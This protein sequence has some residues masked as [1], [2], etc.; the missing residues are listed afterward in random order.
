MG[1]GSFPGAVEF[2]F[3]GFK[4]D[5]V[6]EGGLAGAGD[7][8][9]AEEAAEGEADV[10]VFEVV[11]AG[12]DDFEAIF[13]LDAAAFGG[14][15]DL[16]FAGEVLGGNRL[17]AVEDGFDRSLGDDPPP[18]RHRAGSDVDHPVR[19]ANRILIMLDDDDRVADIGQMPQ[20]A[21]QPVV[22]ALV[23][24]DGRLV[25]DIAHADEAGTHLGRQPDAL[26][27]AARERARLPVERQVA[28]PDVIHETQ[29]RFDLF[30][31]GGRDL[32]RLRGQVE[33]VEELHRPDDRQLRQLADILSADLH[34]EGLGLQPGPAAL[35]AGLLGKVIME[36]GFDEL[37][38]GVVPAALEI[39]HDALEVGAILRFVLRAGAV[40]E[41][42]ANFGRQFLER[43]VL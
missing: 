7:A 27:F 14:G 36:A 16:V 28:E 12:A 24:P 10:D 30:E 3:E 9:D 37:A 42:V 35:L 38:F 39:R 15:D 29:A 21:D 8:G 17:R 1:A 5:V 13:E 34:G 11:F 43:V 33:R 6:D 4:E 40:H 32:R 20:G 23:E 26:E 31:H 18:M 22:I 25:E 41:N 2:A 19:G